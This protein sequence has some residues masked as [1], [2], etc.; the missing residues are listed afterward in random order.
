MDDQI[1]SSR[2][3][4]AL[5]RGLGSLIPVSEPQG[6]L[7]QI[8]VDDLLPGDGQ[9]RQHFNEAALAELSNSIAEHGIIQPL[10]VRKRLGGQHEIIAG[11]RRWRA[12]RLAGLKTVPCV[13]SDIANQDTLTVA[14][15]ENIQREDLNVIE[16]A[17]SYQRLNDQMGLSQEQI[18]KAVGKDRSTIANALRLLKLPGK[19]Q[20]LVVEKR[21]T[22]GHAR[23]LLSLRDTDLIQQIGDQ[24]AE[25]GFSVRHT[26]EL[27]Q[28]RRLANKLS[29]KRVAG[30]N[31]SS[32]EQREIRRK[33]EQLLATKVEFKEERGAGNMTIHFSSTEQLNSILDR[34]GIVL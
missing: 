25:Q 24:I 4:H 27:V 8:S 9:P 23:A 21:M 31:H 7:Q 14:L 12:A 33:L 13:I 34:L 11:E 18:A 22:M 29:H 16:E 10:I 26:E 28:K 1:P 15:V 3:R 19:T 20:R 6:A 32:L 2:N 17:E 5:G 30:E